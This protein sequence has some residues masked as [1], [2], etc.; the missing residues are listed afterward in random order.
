VERF[1]DQVRTINQ[2]PKFKSLQSD[3]VGVTE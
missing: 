3:R 1:I 2:G